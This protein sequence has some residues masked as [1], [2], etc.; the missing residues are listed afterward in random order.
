L[1]GRLKP[2]AYPGYTIKPNIYGSL[3]AASLGIPAVPNVS[4]LGTAFMKNG[5]LQQVVTRLPRVSFS[6]APAVFFQN[7]EDRHFFIERKL[8]RE[9]Q[10]RVLPGSGIDLDRFTPAPLPHDPQAFYSWD[11]C[12][13]PKVSSSLSRPRAP[14][15]P[16]CLVLGSGCSG[17]STRAIARR[18]ILPSSKNGWTSA[19]RVAAP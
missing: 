6:R 11:G 12:L 7:E 9:G 15:G 3:A 19:R 10:V 1:L 17:L 18:F 5:P 13:A 8:V 14:C 4:G 16:F 2:A